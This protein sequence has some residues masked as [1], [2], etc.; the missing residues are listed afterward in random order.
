MCGWQNPLW[1]E[2]QKKEI[3]VTWV[4]REE[5]QSVINITRV[6]HPKT[7]KFILLVQR[8]IENCVVYIDFVVPQVC[9]VCQAL[10]NITAG[11]QFPVHFKGYFA[12]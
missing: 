7:N 1:S 5:Y 8:L 6:L 12:T 10:N 9:F 11:Q 2:Q 4:F 3:K